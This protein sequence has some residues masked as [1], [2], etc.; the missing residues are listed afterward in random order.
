MVHARE[1]RELLGDRNGA[2]V[3]FRAAEITDPGDAT[4][5]ACA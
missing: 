5:P 3:A 4:A 2:I 1:V